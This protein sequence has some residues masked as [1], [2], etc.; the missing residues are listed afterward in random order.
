MK[1]FIEKIM[2]KSNLDKDFNI[3]LKTI[4]F[5]FSEIIDSKID[6]IKENIKNS[7]KEENYFDI[8][9][10][11]VSK[12]EIDIL[13]AKYE[14][15][16]IIPI[17]NLDNKSLL[18]NIKTINRDNDVHIVKS[19]LYKQ[20]YYKGSLNNLEILTNNKKYEGIITDSNGVKF[21]FT[22][23]LSFDKSFENVEKNLFNVFNN[24]NIKWK[25]LFSP[26]IRRIFNVVI[27]EILFNPQEINDISEVKLD[28]HEDFD[29]DLFPVWNIKISEKKFQGSTQ[30][31]EN[32]KYKVYK[33]S[34][35]KEI[36]Y[37]LP[38]REFFDVIK[39][40]NSLNIYLFE[41]DDDIDIWQ[42][43]TFYNEIDKELTND[44]TLTS[45]NIN[46]DILTL[47]SDFRPRTKL[48]VKEFLKSVD[49]G[50]IN[51]IIDIDIL[52]NIDTREKIIEKNNFILYH[53][54]LINEFIPYDKKNTIYIKLNLKNDNYKFDIVNY[55]LSVLDYTYPEI[56][57]LGVE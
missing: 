21:K 8:K 26:Y 1:N 4:F 32:A 25:G 47:L 19:I 56:N 24:N 23:H 50:N 14:I 6:I 42:S 10:W 35:D 46:E 38:D 5:K 48:E 7:F 53:N 11:L 17:I 27:D 31:S 33:F 44:K 52:K 13:Q 20:L 18:K 39:K 3:I 2:L 22:Y 15:Y 40:D 41:T 16:P 28:L 54:F 51:E 37:Y 55:V 12:S 34:Y 43:Y 29:F 45:S 57:W 36:L 9:T 49:L 30:L